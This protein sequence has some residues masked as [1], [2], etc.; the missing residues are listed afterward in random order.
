MK[1]TSTY[2]TGELKPYLVQEGE[3]ISF[4]TS[5]PSRIGTFQD[6]WFTGKYNHVR[7][8]YVH[9][10]H[11]ERLG[12]VSQEDTE[13]IRKMMLKGK[14]EILTDGRDCYTFYGDWCKITNMHN[15][16]KINESILERP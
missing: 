12:K 8:I 9:S 7:N 15:Y 4:K 6:V 14:T 2:T 3:R 16:T 5:K 1:V 11:I 13:A 10:F